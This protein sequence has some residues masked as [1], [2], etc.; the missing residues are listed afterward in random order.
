MKFSRSAALSSAPPILTSALPNGPA[1]ACKSSTRAASRARFR[2]PP[3][4]FSGTPAIS[5]ASTP[6]LSSQSAN[7]FD[8]LL[9]QRRH[10]NHEAILHVALQQPL[11]RIVDLLNWNQLDVR[12]DSVLRAKIQHLLRFPDAT[13]GRSR[14]P[15]PLHQ[16]VKRRNRPRLL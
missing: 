5:T 7:N 13:Y 4:A 6:G 2:F 9:L 10:I 12:S 14:Q 16:K 11:V 3:R 1:T 15:P 8:R